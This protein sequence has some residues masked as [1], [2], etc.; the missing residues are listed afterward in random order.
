MCL[1]FAAAYP[2][3][4]S[5]LIPYGTCARILRAPDY[6]SGSPTETL[7]KVLERAEETWDTGSLSA[8]HFAPSL[9]HDQSFR[10]SRARFERFAVS[11][12]GIKAL[13]RMFHETDARHTLSV[14]RLLNAHRPRRSGIPSN[15]GSNGRDPSRCSA[16]PLNLSV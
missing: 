10:R 12:A 11:P 15:F 4:T 13:L 5:A 1:M 7:G 14:I 16:P 9:A 2:A 3:R 8:D 6:Q